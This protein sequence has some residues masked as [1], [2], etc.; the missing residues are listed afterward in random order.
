MFLFLIYEATPAPFFALQPILIASLVEWGPLKIS[1][2]CMLSINYIF[3]PPLQFSP[4]NVYSEVSAT[5]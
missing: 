5:I 4:M 3:V 1:C 2:I